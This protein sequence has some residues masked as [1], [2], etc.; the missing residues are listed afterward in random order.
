MKTIYWT[1]I[2][3]TRTL[4]GGT[5]GEEQYDIPPLSYFDPVILKSSLPE[6]TQNI[7]YLR[8]PAF[9]ELSR[10][11]FALKFPFDYEIEINEH[12]ATTKDLDQK[13]YDMFLSLSENVLQLKS[14][15]LFISED[16]LMMSISHPY[17]HSNRVTKFGN[18]LGG[19]YDIGQWARPVL[20]SLLIHENPSVLDLQRGDVYSYV[21]FHTKDKI[22]L[23][24]FEYTQAIDTIVTDCW[25]MKN[26][27]RKIIPLKLCYDVYTRHRYHKRIIKEIKKNII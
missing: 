6:F 20:C 18:V 19:E 14:A 11:T 15:Y 27:S 5:P 16:S 9:T 13:F 26:S 2:S 25:Q 12:N 24:K 10:N 23:K 8:C 4:D 7:T 1:N 17:L 21:K 3:T 22:T